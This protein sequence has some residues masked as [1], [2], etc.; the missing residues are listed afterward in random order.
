MNCNNPPPL[1]RSDDKPYDM[2]ARVKKRK[3][4]FTETRRPNQ[5]K[6]GGRR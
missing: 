2:N 1:R 3:N 4:N 6:T 5:E